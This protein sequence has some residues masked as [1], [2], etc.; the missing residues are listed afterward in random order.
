MDHLLNS[1]NDH[2]PKLAHACI[3]SAV[4][5]IL[6]LG[7][8]IE[9]QAMFIAGFACLISVFLMQCPTTHERFL[10]LYM[11]RRL[12][13]WCRKLITR[14][15]SQ[16]LLFSELQMYGFR[17]EYRRRQFCTPFGLNTVKFLGFCPHPDQTLL[18]IKQT[19]TRKVKPPP[20][21]S[22]WNR[23]YYPVEILLSRTL[24]WQRPR[25]SDRLG[26]QYADS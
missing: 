14:E 9:V 5:P 8:W 2:G 26:K 11:T 22:H 20:E 15:K 13:R 21:K 19:S 16:N 18:S 1:N 24:W 6:K 25:M 12:W 23:V 10:Q 17:I 3:Q 4:E 7:S